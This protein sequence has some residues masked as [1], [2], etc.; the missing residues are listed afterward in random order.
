MLAS[1]PARMAPTTSA[2][3]QSPWTAII[4]GPRRA[5]C[6]ACCGLG[7]AREGS[8]RLSLMI[9]ACLQQSHRGARVMPI[10]IFNTFDDPSGFTTN[11]TTEAF[12][13]NGMDQIVGYY[14]NG[15]GIHGI[16][17]SCGTYNT[18]DAP[19]A[20]FGTFARGINDAGQIVGSYNDG[21]SHGFLFN[22]HPIFWPQLS[23]PQRSFGHPRHL[24]IR[25]QCVGPDC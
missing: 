3:N 12:G 7:R 20:T 17:E 21:Q 11:G 4:C 24:C 25:H 5:S 10:Q 22:P 14:H 1:T 13:V 9:D 2:V 15:S 18:L 19:T 16:L 8:P 6:I 23:Y